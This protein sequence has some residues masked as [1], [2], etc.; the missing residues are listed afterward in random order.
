MTDTLFFSK[1]NQEQ[2]SELWIALTYVDR[3][4]N[5][6]LKKAQQARERNQRTYI[7]NQNES[8]FSWIKAKIVDAYINSSMYVHCEVVFPPTE[9]SLH[10]RKSPCYGVY[11]DQGVF[12]GER[13]FANPAYSWI[14]LKVNRSEYTKAVTFCVNQVGKPYDS[15]GMMR[16]VIFPKKMNEDRWWCV[17]FAIRALQEAG[18]LRYVNPAAMDVDDLVYV[19]SK[20]P[21]RFYAVTPMDEDAVIKVIST[22]ETVKPHKK[23]KKKLPPKKEKRDNFF[24]GDD[25]V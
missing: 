25:I 6:E 16:S 17:S 12:S 19:L 14:F 15:T 23:Q 11:S 4:K 9:S 20:H 24:E 13:T 7:N 8:I 21:R 2:R 10:E 3:V 5:D 1:M 22:A 18:I